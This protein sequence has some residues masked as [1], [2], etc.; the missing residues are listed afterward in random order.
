MSL[1]HAPS[2]QRRHSDAKSPIGGS[3]NPL[4]RI[5]E[6]ILTDPIALARVLDDS[7]IAKAIGV[8]DRTWDRLKAQGDVPPQTFLSA[9]RRGRR[10]I[11]VVA[12][13]DARRITANSETG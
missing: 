6:R 3:D 7:Q 5:I 12:W 13:L 8:S 9:N 1:E 11:D 2:R 10:L 4:A